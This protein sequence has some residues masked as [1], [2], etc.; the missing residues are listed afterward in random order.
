MNEFLLRPCR[1][2]ILI[3][4]FIKRHS[5]ILV[6][7]C[8]YAGVAGVLIP[9]GIDDIRMADVFSVDESGAAVVVRH[10]YAS[11]TYDLVTFKY[12]SLFYF[13]PLTTLH[14]YSLFADVS[15]RSILTILR[16]F[17]A[18]S[19]LICIGLTYAFA[20]RLYGT[21]AGLVAAVMLLVSPSVMRWGVETH[22]DL[23]LLVLVI[24][25]LWQSIRVMER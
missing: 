21:V 10:Q 25:F 16:I 7:L 24:L 15:D 17:C 6:A 23:P 18:L 5:L 22:P 4:S 20:R 9:I 1:N 8:V 3:Y 14:I 2:R 13:V 12:G 19:G 11:G